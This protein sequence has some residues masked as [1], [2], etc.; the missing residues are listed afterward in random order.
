MKKSMMP[1]L[2]LQARWLGVAIPRDVSTLETME[3]EPHLLYLLHSL[4]DG[5]VGE[6]RAVFRR[7]DGSAKVAFRRGLLPFD[8]LF[9]RRRKRLLLL[10]DLREPGGD[11]AFP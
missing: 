6:S 3:A 9:H 5:K 11:G 2:T 10:S 4:V 7:V 8:A 1:L